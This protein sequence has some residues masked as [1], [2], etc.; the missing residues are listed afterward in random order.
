MIDEIKQKT[1]FEEYKI[2]RET[3]INFDKIL[4]EIRKSTIS[5]SFLIF[6]IALG[7]FGIKGTILGFIPS[8]FVVAL[9]GIEILMV[10]LLFYLEIHYRTYLTRTANLACKF[11]EEL[12]LGVVLKDKSICDLNCD[13][14][15]S[16]LRKGSISKCL[17][18]EHNIGM[19][20]FTRIAHYNLYIFLI[21]LGILFLNVLLQKKIGLSDLEI[22]FYL[23]ITA[24][25]I[26][27]TFYNIAKN[28]IKKQEQKDKIEKFDNELFFHI[29]FISIVIILIYSTYFILEYYF[30]SLPINVN[31]S[32]AFF[33]SAIGFIG[34]KLTQ[35]RGSN[36]NN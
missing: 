26:F 11:E 31:Y 34:I 10:I 3:A 5:L 28:N 14:N 25:I 30:K 29:F 23:I 20:F 27:Y 4:L 33:S 15:E 24:S 18:C 6:G 7:V 8:D 22:L 36:A 12:D 13:S 35:N 32:I 2:V 1:L 19:G 9:I 21:A 17:K 16:G